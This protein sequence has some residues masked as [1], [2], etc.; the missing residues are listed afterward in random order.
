M[1]F[2]YLFYCFFLIGC[3]NMPNPVQS[4]QEKV[5]SIIVEIL[6]STEESKIHIIWKN[7]NL[8]SDWNGDQ[9]CVLLDNMEK[10]QN[11]RKQVEF[12]LYSLEEAEAK[13]KEAN[14]EQL[15]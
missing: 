2:I 10:L 4:K 12:L 11:Y 14:A 15:L 7:H 5:P 8:I 13:M 9:T 3:E 6:D 1:K